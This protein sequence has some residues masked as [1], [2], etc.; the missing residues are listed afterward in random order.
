MLVKYVIR[1]ISKQN[2]ATGRYNFP[3]IKNTNIN[4]IAATTITNFSSLCNN[5][6]EANDTAVSPARLLA[7]ETLKSFARRTGTR[8]ISS[9]YVDTFPLSSCQNGNGAAILAAMTTGTLMLM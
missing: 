6:D 5:I 3:G 7:Q 2:P 4:N 1:T 9:Q 8:T